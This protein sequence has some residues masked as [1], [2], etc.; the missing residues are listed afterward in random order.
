MSAETF[1]MIRNLSLE[2]QSPTRVE[3]A[4]HNYFTF[5]NKLTNRTISI[6]LV[7]NKG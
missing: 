2:T 7:Q 5:N 4:M 3:K 6:C 1:A